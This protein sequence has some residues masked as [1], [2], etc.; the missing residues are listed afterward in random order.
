MIYSMDKKIGIGIAIVAIV[1]VFVIFFISNDNNS[2]TSSANNGLISNQQ[3]ITSQQPLPTGK[4]IAL[5]LN[6]TMVLTQTP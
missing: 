2:S 1:A 4:H 5:D 6:E 3:Q